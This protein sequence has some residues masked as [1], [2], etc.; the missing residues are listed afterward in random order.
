M[1]LEGI[2]EKLTPDEQA[3][4]TGL[5]DTDPLTGVY[6]RRKFDRDIELVA[7]MSERSKK[8]SGLIIVDIDHFKKYNDKFGHQEGDRVLRD[9]TRSIENSLRGYD[10]IH[11]YRY[12]GEEFVVMVMDITIRDAFNV[13]DR[14]RKNVKKDC[15][16]T[17]SVGVSHYKEISDNIQSLLSHADDALYRAKRKGRDRVEVFSSMRR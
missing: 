17:I 7:A 1:D 2:Y 16:I 6:N 15:D 11:L 10:K 9:V 12:G 3:Y 8:G 4:L 13:G 14:I 5:I